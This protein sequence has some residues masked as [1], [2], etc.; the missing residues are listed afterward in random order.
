MEPKVADLKPAVSPATAPAIP[1]PSLN[2]ETASANVPSSALVLAKL[3]EYLDGLLPLFK[4]G[5][6]PVNEETARAQL[7]Q[8]FYQL[9]D[10]LQHEKESQPLPPKQKPETAWVDYTR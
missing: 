10:A 7:L 8:Y 3:S 2:A 4:N 5:Q 9:L 1:A 6:Q